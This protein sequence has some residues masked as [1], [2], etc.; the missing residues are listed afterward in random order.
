ML[1]ETPGKNKKGFVYN[2]NCSV[3]MNTF[4]HAICYICAVTYLEPDLAL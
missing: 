2:F 3:S 1:W 4:C